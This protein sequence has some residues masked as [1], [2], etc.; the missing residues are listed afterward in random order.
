MSDATNEL[1]AKLSQQIDAARGK[2]D[3]LKKNIASVHE[4]D[5][6]ALQRKQAE[7]GQ[8][9]AQQKERAKQLKAEMASWQKEKVAHT[10]EAVASWRQRHELEKLEKR[11]ERAADYAIDMVT[12]AALDVDDAE[13]AVLDAL[14]ARVEADVAA[15][16]T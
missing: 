16:S 3:N 1:K 13:Q 9:I 10:K 7:I 15:A 6:Q 8:R 4:E 11:A 12:A 5:V 2:L 14:A